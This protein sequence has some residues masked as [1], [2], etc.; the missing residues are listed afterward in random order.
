MRISIATSMSDHS[1][2]Y[3][4][5]AANIS[6]MHDLRA[7]HPPLPT[8]GFENSVFKSHL[9]TVVCPWYYSPC[10]CLKPSCHK[11]L[12]LAP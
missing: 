9:Y 8:H 1:A 4:V 6:I 3:P 12:I 11:T 10:Q 5:I 7:T 2:S